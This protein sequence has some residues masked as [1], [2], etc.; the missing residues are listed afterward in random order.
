MRLKSLNIILILLVILSVSL[1]AKIVP[2][3]RAQ[4]IIYVDPATA[5]GVPEQYI[6]IS[7]NITGVTTPGVA[8]WEVKLNYNTEVLSTNTGL[9]DE[10]DFLKSAGNTQF[11]EVAFP[12]ILQ[13][14]AFLTQPGSASGSGSLA[15][16]QFQVLATGQSTLH[17]Y[18]TLLLD[19][20]GDP[21]SHSTEDGLFYTASPKADFIY[22]P[23]P[24][25]WGGRTPPPYRNPVVGE[26][27]TFNAT[28]D[29]PTG[30]GSKDPDGTI[31]NYAW[32][33]GDGSTISGSDPVVTY[34]YTANGSYIVNLVVTDDDGLTGSV[35]KQITID[36]R[37]IAIIDIQI[38]GPAL[39][40]P[41]APAV[42]NVTVANQGT[43][44]EYYNVTAY[45][46]SNPIWYNKTKNQRDFSLPLEI[47]PVTHL[48]PAP[49][50]PPNKNSTITVVWNTTGVAEST[51][52]IK[53]TATLVDVND[54][55]QQITG[56]TDT[57]DNTYQDGT[58]QLRLDVPVASFTFS[59]A[60]PIVS[61]IISFNASASLDEPPGYITS[62]QWDFDDGATDTGVTVTHAYTNPGTYSVTLNVTDND[63]LSST[64]SKNVVV[65]KIGSD[66]SISASPTVVTFG[67]SITI[68]GDIT[69]ERIGENV[70]IRFRS[71]DE[72]WNNLASALTDQSGQYTYTWT[73]ATVGAYDL[74][75]SWLGDANTEPAISEIV[76]V[77]VNQRSSTIQIDV[78]PVT[79]LKGE[80]VT[81]SGNLSPL[82]SQAAITIKY[83]LEAE[84]WSTLSTVYTDSSGNFTY[85]WQISEPGTYKI[86][87]SWLGDAD[88]LGA[89]SSVETVNV[90]ALEEP[91]SPL[92]IYVAAA[93]VGVIILVA[94][95]A[96]LK[97]RKR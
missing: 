47:D 85:D 39:V 91:M 94:L 3:A 73:T 69:P 83:R 64:Q 52:T 21:I 32:D 82:L 48:P 17:L 9:I 67:E 18:D 34:A 96:F 40:K 25:S 22:F 41:G 76:S 5:T 66:I 78:S 95:V 11:S 61:E 19:E 2:P 36:I 1:T 10:G 93:G 56:E 42:I 44:S 8:A 23:Y 65:G 27:I 84:E 62:Y 7:I 24:E 26:T 75:A 4:P 46:D 16:I 71:Q 50:L 77:T 80:N 20:N 59:P 49:A 35:E 38:I 57:V 53:A 63:G 12:S 97:L 68:E 72:T 88:T 13:F 92:V 30:T 37:D 81:I 90:E 15:T 70:T 79:V 58:V 45:Y 89:E 29:P 86:K 6:T 14:G 87:A 28:Y 43:V 33:F 54:P 74:R 51:Y 31:V 55:S 60:S